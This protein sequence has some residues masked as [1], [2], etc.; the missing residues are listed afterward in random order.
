M[1]TNFS[2]VFDANKIYVNNKLK[3]IQLIQ[4]WDNSLAEEADR[5]M[6]E[7]RMGDGYYSR[8]EHYAYYNGGD[9]YYNIRRTFDEW[10]NGMNGFDWRN[11]EGDYYQVLSITFF[12][13]HI[14]I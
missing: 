2:L 10:N 6:S 11:S 5:R 1:P 13:C 14:S 8:G 7:C 4:E 3:K 12:S 9:H